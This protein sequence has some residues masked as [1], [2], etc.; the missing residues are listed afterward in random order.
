MKKSYSFL[1]I[2]LLFLFVACNNENKTSQPET[3]PKTAADTLMHD[4]MDGHNEAMS[5][6]GKLNTMEKGLQTIIDSIEKLPVKTKRALA[7]YKIQLDSALKNLRSAKEGMEKWMDSFNMDSAITNMEQRMK[8]LADEKL[9]VTNVK[10]N[11][12]N[13]LQKADSLLKSKF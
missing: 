3:T 12:L 5:R 2:F 4:V 10:E 8:Y 6:M 13:G 7:P 9:K 11:I 1:L